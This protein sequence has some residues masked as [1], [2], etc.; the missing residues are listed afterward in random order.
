MMLIG[1][2]HDIVQRGEVCGR[3][4]SMAGARNTETLLARARESGTRAPARAIA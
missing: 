3:R 4:A 1:G 2:G